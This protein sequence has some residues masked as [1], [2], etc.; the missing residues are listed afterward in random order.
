MVKYPTGPATRFGALAEPN[1][2]RMVEQLGRHRE[3]S[4][5]DLAEPLDISLPASLK[6]VRVLER[7]GLVRR[8]KEGRTSY[9]QLNKAAFDDLFGWLMSQRKFWEA[10]LDRLEKHINRKH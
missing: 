1:R 6:H 8:R 2:L 4:L 7:E 10:S 5:S 3:L 9:Y